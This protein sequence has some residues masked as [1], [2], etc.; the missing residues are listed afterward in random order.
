M[1]GKSFYEHTT[2]RKRSEEAKKKAIYKKCLSEVELIL[3]FFPLHPAHREA[4]K[5]LKLRAFNISSHVGC[6]Y[7]TST[8]TTKKV[9]CISKICLLKR[10]KLFF[11]RTIYKNIPWAII[12]VT[13]PVTLKI[14]G[15]KIYSLRLL[16]RNLQWNENRSR[17]SYISRC[18]WKIPR[19]LFFKWW[20]HKWLLRI[21]QMHPIFSRLTFLRG[22]GCQIFHLTSHNDSH[23]T[24]SLTNKKSIFN[25]PQSIK[26]HVALI[27]PLITHK[28][29]FKCHLK[30]HHNYLR[31]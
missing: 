23:V 5:C 28:D 12:F 18:F 14:P 24:K 31:K 8:Y 6:S 3:H 16:K 1:N 4:S 2:S 7:I 27:F 15:K 29:I 13:L 20:Y 26:F 17:E 19:N 11:L 10:S 9:F 25:F 30:P 22:R 21:L